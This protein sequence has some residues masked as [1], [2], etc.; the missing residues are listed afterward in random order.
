MMPEN[1][2]AHR[3]KNSV[4]SAFCGRMVMESY[5]MPL[6][7]GLD[8]GT[9]NIK[10]VVYDSASGQIVSHAAQPTP[11]THPR[12]DWTEFDAEAV[13][14]VTCACIG[15]AVASL[16]APQRIEAVAVAS[17]GEAGVPLDAKGHP[18]YPIIAWHDP[19][20]EQQAQWLRS[21]LG[22]E[23]IHRITGQQLKP[24]FGIAKILWLKDNVPSVFERMALW[25]SVED[26][27]LWRLTG[28]AA[29]D[30]TIAA[31]T[32][33]FDQQQTTW[34]ADLL[35]LCGLAAERLP[36][37][38]FSG[39]VVGMVTPQAAQETGLQQGVWVATGGHDH[40]CGALA[41]GAIVPGQV[42]D[43]SG[44]AQGIVLPVE[45][46]HGGG[47]ALTAGFSC[48]RHVVRGRFVI[49]GGLTSAGGALHWLVSLMG[50]KDAHDSLF[51]E[52]EQAGPGAHG[53]FC[54]P[55]LLAGG[56]PYGDGYPLGAFI[57]L[58]LAHT[59]GDL[60][61]ALIEGQAYALRQN[62]ERMA[63]VAPVADGHMLA[64]GGGN[65]EPLLLQ[66]KADVCQRPVH[67]P[68]IPEAVAVGA[69][70]LAGVAVG[71]FADEAQGAASVSCSM[72]RY[73]PDPRRAAVYDA[74]YRDV[75]AGL[76]PSLQQV[77]G[78]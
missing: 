55:Y 43:S 30:F 25:L 18:L 45:R 34:S 13:W 23:A 3:V 39:T 47:A 20:S 78:D 16:P 24:T 71:V 48:Y 11:T 9:T 7:L 28:V 74:W 12:P 29:T 49:M 32:M 41:A 56:T 62:L 38:V 61:R 44:T 5:D 46:F 66:T 42:L 40:L 65:R 52:A 19:R 6:L 53:V 33:L 10:A 22:A 69:A 27:I 77:R 68:A 76:Y 31:R 26:Y 75:Y 36:R 37:P 64:I 35:A 59:R 54:L 51:R 72:Q 67:V 21:A 15:Q 17:M 60:L 2:R 58:T 70:L 14:H 8:I 4:F 57:G 73:E 50:G 1:H 63:Q